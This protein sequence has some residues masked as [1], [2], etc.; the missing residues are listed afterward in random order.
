[1]DDCEAFVMHEEKCLIGVWIKLVLQLDQRGCLIT[2]IALKISNPLVHS[3]TGWL[4]FIKI[5]AGNIRKEEWSECI[6]KIQ[7]WT[8][9][10]TCIIYVSMCN[11]PMKYGP[12]HMYHWN[13][14]IQERRKRKKISC[15]KKIFNQ[16][17]S[18]NAL[19]HPSWRDTTQARNFICWRLILYKLY[20]C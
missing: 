12:Y 7:K 13:N 10:K 5:T 1:M 8:R 18:S 2:I 9:S 14:F 20:T 4:D 15:S 16:I 3:E 19:S 17:C 6:S 11:I